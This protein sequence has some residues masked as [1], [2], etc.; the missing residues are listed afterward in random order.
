MARALPELGPGIVASAR[1][2]RGSSRRRGGLIGALVA[3]CGA[4]ALL[5]GALPP[6]AVA[7][8]FAVEGVDRAR[9]LPPAGATIEAYQNSGYRLRWTDDEVIVDVEATPVG[10]SRRF[11]TPDPS[12]E[13][14]VA[15]LAR[16]VTTGSRTEYDAASRILGWLARNITYELNRQE[17]QTPDAVLERRSGYCTGVARLAVAMMLSVGLEA[18]EVAGYVY[19]GGE[20]GQPQG[21]HRWIEVRFD[22]GWV[23]SDP[24]Y[25]HHWVPANYLRLGSERLNLAEGTE[26]L[27]LERHDAVVAVD[28]YPFASTGIRAR[29]NSDR[30]LA[31]ALRVQ[32][33]GGDAGLAVLEGNATRWTHVLLEGATTFVGLDPGSYRLRLRLGGGAV[34]ER[35]VELARRQRTTLLLAPERKSPRPQDSNYHSPTSRA[36]PAEPYGEPKT[37]GSNE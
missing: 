5:V 33:D 3:A 8:G 23:F 17:A 22:R 14:S 29:R 31:A 9:V 34:V 19:G 25:S 28:L 30:Q 36:A 13:G 15:R 24:L 37:I 10:S 4:F 27:L 26:G 35:R 18:R 11:A 32:L 20:G 16:S 7:E 2:S 21:Y 12:L 6:V 1:A